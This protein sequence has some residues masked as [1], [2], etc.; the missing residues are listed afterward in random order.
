MKSFLR[1]MLPLV[2]LSSLTLSSCVTAYRHGPPPPAHR[3]Y[4]HGYGRPLPPP[5]PPRGPYGYYR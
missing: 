1:W 5:P 3:Y 4:R 2:V